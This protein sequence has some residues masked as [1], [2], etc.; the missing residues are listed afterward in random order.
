MFPIC[1]GPC[2][3][4]AVT[5]GLANL[6]GRPMSV[7]AE[8][9]CRINSTATAPRTTVK[10]VAEDF[11]AFVRKNTT[12]NTQLLPSPRSLE[13]GLNFLLADLVPADIFPGFIGSKS[14]KIIARK[15]LLLA[16]LE[17]RGTLN[18]MRLND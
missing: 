3:V 4:A 12:S 13:K 10:E 14:K 5:A 15:K 2:H 18:P 6:N 7:L 17:L 8:E 1:G 16:K 9:F 11:L